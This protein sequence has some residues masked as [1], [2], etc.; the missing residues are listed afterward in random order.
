M[1]TQNDNKQNDNDHNSEKLPITI[2][3]LAVE[4]LDQVENMDVQFTMAELV[5]WVNDAIDRF[6][7]EANEERDKRVGSS[8]TVRTLRHYQ[9]LE[10][11]DKP[12]KNGRLAIYGFR[13]YL[14]ALLIRKLL[15]LRYSPDQIRETLNV[16]TNKRYKE[17]LFADINIAPSGRVMPSSTPTY[18]RIQTLTRITLSP[19]A[20]LLLHTPPHRMS[21]DERLQLLNAIQEILEI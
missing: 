13:H 12:E 21:S 4:E 15:Y 10:C 14:Q 19:D 8:F 1:N 11:L 9:T 5:D 3:K 20:E 6:Y 7:P 2:P 18:P 17:M 16:K